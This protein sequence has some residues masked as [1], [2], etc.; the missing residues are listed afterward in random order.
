MKPW[1]RHENDA[2]P[3]LKIGWVARRNHP[4]QT[5]N[6]DVPNSSSQ[7]RNLGVPILAEELDKQGRH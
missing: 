5:S 7:A 6:Y 2:V 1:R 4:L 3:D